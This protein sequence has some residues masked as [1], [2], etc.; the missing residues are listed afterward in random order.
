MLTRRIA[1]SG[2][3]NPDVHD[4]WTG[5]TTRA[6]YACS[7]NRVR[8]EVSIFGAD[9]K[10]RGLWGGKCLRIRNQKLP[11]VRRR[12]P[13]ALR[14]DTFFNWKIVPVSKFCSHIYC[15][16]PMGWGESPYNGL[17]GEAPPERGS[18]FRLAVYKRVR[19]SRD[20]V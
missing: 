15:M 16:Y 10:D 7:K 2:D 3:E 1:A 6:L 12:V 13:K 8:P 18:L 11:H 20:E 9:Q 14:A 4:S 5:N 19:I 17:H